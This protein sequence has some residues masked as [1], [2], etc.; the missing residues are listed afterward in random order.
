LRSKPFWTRKTHSL[1]YEQLDLLAQGLVGDGLRIGVV[2]GGEKTLTEPDQLT[3]GK[4]VERHILQRLLYLGGAPT[5]GEELMGVR[6]GEHD[7]DRTERGQGLGVAG[8]R[9]C[10][11]LQAR[12]RAERSVE[13]DDDL[14]V[15]RLAEHRR[16]G[17]T[18]E[19]LSALGNAVVEDLEIARP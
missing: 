6:I 13:I 16:H 9:S 4:R 12:G 10:R 3:G 1:L 11:D 14:P 2:D 8:Q 17:R 5:R 18:A 19:L 15:A 7:L